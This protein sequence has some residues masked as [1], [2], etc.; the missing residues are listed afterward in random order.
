MATTATF[1]TCLALGGPCPIVRMLDQPRGA[2]TCLSGLLG[3]A[4]GHLGGPLSEFLR[5]LRP[6]LDPICPDREAGLLPYIQALPGLE[7][8]RMYS[9]DMGPLLEE[10]IAID[11]GLGS[12][13]CAAWPSLHT[14]VVDEVED[15]Q[16]AVLAAFVQHRAAVGAPL[17][18]LIIETEPETLPP[19]TLKVFKAAQLKARHL[20][21]I[22]GMDQ[23]L[24]PSEY[25]CWSFD[26]DRPDYVPW[27]GSWYLQD[28][29][30]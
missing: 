27:D 22:P 17:R 19:D 6:R 11:R 12:D 20:S 10:A 28:Q 9:E 4:V 30:D 21:A 25:L 14:L 8:L 13:V 24:Y 5:G 29:F 1:A 3:A 15:S 26:Y 23:A 7:V 18:T 16:A 2:S